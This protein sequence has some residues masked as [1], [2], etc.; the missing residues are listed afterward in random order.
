MTTGSAL[1]STT[2]RLV[3][4]GLRVAQVVTVKGIKHSKLGTVTKANGPTAWVLWDGSR[5]SS[6]ER[7]DNLTVT[8]GFQP[9]E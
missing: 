3:R 2:L 5:G 6:Y 9:T 1:D 4:K 7:C 8:N